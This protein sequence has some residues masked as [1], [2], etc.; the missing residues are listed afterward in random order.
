MADETRSPE[1]IHGMATAAK[2]MVA[3]ATQW[4]I[5]LQSLPVEDAEAEYLHSMAEADDMVETMRT[6]Q[7]EYYQS[8][9]SGDWVE[10][11]LAEICDPFGVESTTSLLR[12]ALTAPRWIG[13][14]ESSFV[15]TDSESVLQHCAHSPGFC[16]KSECLIG[17]SHWQHEMTFR[18]AFEAAPF[19]SDQVYHYLDRI[20]GLSRIEELRDITTFQDVLTICRTEREDARRILRPCVCVEQLQAIINYEAAWLLHSNCGKPA[21][22]QRDFPTP[23]WLSERTGTIPVVQGDDETSERKA[24]SVGYYSTEKVRLKARS[25]KGKPISKSTWQRIRRQL[26]EEIQNHPTSGAQKVRFTELAA[27]TLHLNTENIVFKVP[28]PT[29]EVV[30]KSSESRQ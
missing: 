29:M 4:M 15:D 22:R 17:M 25:A 12:Q 9:A 26:G 8:T 19:F 1:S 11:F 6:M 23:F 2:E 5:D 13:L 21:P 10:A 24:Y 30:R 3:S 20:S 18:T 16:L 28:E 7:D 14:T 27:N